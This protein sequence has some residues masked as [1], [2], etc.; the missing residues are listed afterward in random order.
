MQESTIYD[1]IIQ[2]LID[3]IT[4]LGVSLIKATLLFLIGRFVIKL[5]A[6]LSQRMMKRQKIEESVR[7]FISSTIYILLM[8]L[9]IISIIG[10]LGIQTTSFAALLASAGVA[11]GMALSGNLQNFAGG[12]ILLLFKP[13]RVGDTIESQNFVGTVKEIQV[14][15]TILSVAENKIV[16][17]PNGSVS[18]GAI[19]NL[20]KL[21]VRRL[22]LK[23]PVLPEADF[24]L[25]KKLIEE[26]I[27]TE[28]RIRD[29]PDPKVALQ[30][31]SERGIQILIRVYILR[32]DY[33]EVT[34]QLNKEIYQRFAANGIQFPSSEVKLVS[35]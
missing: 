2:F 15:H 10:V 5:A 14:F 19:V 18:S 11:I 21:D 16:Y 26:I 34:F 25:A 9:L 13:F 3:P 30:S 29:L 12:I 17:L 8:T 4:R 7:S 24:D 33:T 27:A 22:D 6:K 28:S 35:K 1:E 20:N 32:N 31:I 23:I